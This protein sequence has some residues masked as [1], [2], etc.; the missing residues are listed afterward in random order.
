MSVGAVSVTP[1][2]A[3]ALL[4]VRDSGGKGRKSDFS[5]IMRKTH[6][7]QHT[8]S[9][10]NQTHQKLLTSAVLHAEPHDQRGEE[11]EA[12]YHAHHDAD[13]GPHTQG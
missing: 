1:R 6:I 8:A 2:V 7:E 3:M 12:P 4:A 9:P 13:D 11:A 10:N 5:S